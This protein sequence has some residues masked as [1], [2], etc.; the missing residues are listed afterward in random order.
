MVYCV[1]GRVVGRFAGLVRGR[2]VHRGPRVV[3]SRPKPSPHVVAMTPASPLGGLFPGQLQL[4]G[5]PLHLIP[6][7]LLL[8]LWT[9]RERYGHTP[10]IQ[11][12]NCTTTYSIL[13]I[14]EQSC[15]IYTQGVSLS[16]QVNCIISVFPN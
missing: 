5:P 16:T 15:I 7:L 10:Y 1:P 11:S 12:N 13:N 2:H 4:L 14:E 3:V 6:R 9:D 8:G